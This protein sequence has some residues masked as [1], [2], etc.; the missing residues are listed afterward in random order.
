MRQTKLRRV[1]TQERKTFYL[2]E[3]TGLCTQKVLSSYLNT[4]FGNKH[5]Q[6]E[7]RL[8]IQGTDGAAQ[9]IRR[10][11]KSLFEA[12]KVGWLKW[13]MFFLFEVQS[14][15]SRY[16]VREG[17]LF[18]AQNCVER[19][20]GR[21]LFILCLHLKKQKASSKQKQPLP[22]YYLLYSRQ[23]CLHYKYRHCCR[24]WL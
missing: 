2:G 1:S 24:E 5:L 4:F 13:R 22:M 16:S 23:Q 3:Q 15:L 10:G 8:S 14:Q 12:K 17:F 7:K 18:G 21:K 11:R 20:L 9:S 6:M 19:L